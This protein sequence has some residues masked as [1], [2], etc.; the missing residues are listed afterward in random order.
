MVDEPP[1]EPDRGPSGE[2]GR[3]VRQVV[4][5]PCGVDD[6]VRD[7]GLDPARLAAILLDLELDGWVVRQGRRI[8]VGPK[9]RKN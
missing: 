9:A 3:V 7:L 4:E 6:L 2:P 1:L 8:A 5:G